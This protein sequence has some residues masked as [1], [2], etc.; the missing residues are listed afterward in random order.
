MIRAIMNTVID[1]IKF[2]LALFTLIGILALGICIPVFIA[3]ILGCI[4]LF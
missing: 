4:F 2:I 1:V 3:L